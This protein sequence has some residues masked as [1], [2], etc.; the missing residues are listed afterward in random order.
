MIRTGAADVWDGIWTGAVWRPPPGKRGAILHAALVAR[1]CS[2]V[3]R[4]AG[5]RAREIRFTRFLRNG[6]VT[7]AEMAAHAAERTAARAAGRDVVVIQDTSEL[8]LGGRRARANGYG[9][10]GKGGALRGFLLHA[11]LAVDAATGELFGLIEAKV[12]NREGGKVRSRR[13]RATADKESQRWID[14][15]ARA[16]Q[17]LAGARRI[18]MVS[19]RESDIYEYFACRPFNVHQIA[20]ACQDRQIETEDKSA[21]LLFAFIDRLPEKGRFSVNIPDATGRKE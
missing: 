14:G 21:C 18:T 6:S 12:W 20:R 7:A 8:A 13:S 11:V 16:G 15:S 1:P 10:V 9:P 2:C 17:V 4:L 3:R 19:D 5:T